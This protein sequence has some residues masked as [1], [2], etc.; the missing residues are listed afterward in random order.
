MFYRS[1]REVVSYCA[2]F[3]ANQNLI[4]SLRR[5]CV[6]TS[7]TVDCCHKTDEERALTGTW[8]MDEVR[9][10]VQNG[11]RILQLYELHEYNVTSYGPE[12]RE[13]G[14]FAGYIDTFLKLKA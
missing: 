4:Y 1:L 12:T 3:R 7:N 11:Y 5:T 14:L 13:G 6:L 9:L 8:V 10:A 2:S